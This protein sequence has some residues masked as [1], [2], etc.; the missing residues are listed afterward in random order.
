MKAADSDTRLIPIRGVT[1]ITSYS[2]ST[3][4]RRIKA[5]D[6]PRPVIQNSN[7]SRWDAGEIFAWIEEQ[8]DKRDRQEAPSSGS[9]Q[10]SGGAI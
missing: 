3:I 5:G 10:C 1:A 8:R 6:F 9:M 4:M 7:D 2:R